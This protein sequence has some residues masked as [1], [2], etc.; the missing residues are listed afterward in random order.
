MIAS[1]VWFNVEEQAGTL[2]SASAS[3][4]FSHFPSAINQGTGDRLAESTPLLWLRGIPT[5]RSES[6]E[7]RGAA[8]PEP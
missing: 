5:A 6:R 4:H 7:S 2:L 3:L 1:R 8:S